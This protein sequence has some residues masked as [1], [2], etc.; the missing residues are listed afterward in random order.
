G[1]PGVLRL[2]PVRAMAATLAAAGR[3]TVRILVPLP[4]PL[5]RVRSQL[6]P[7]GAPRGT[8]A[9]PHSVVKGCGGRGTRPNQ[10]W[11]G[12]T[13]SSAEGSVGTAQSASADDDGPRWTMGLAPTQGARATAWSR[14]PKKEGRARCT[15]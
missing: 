3:E 14:I 9:P 11:F 8:I 6:T 2:G 15:A 10:D 5:R 4:Y 13:A 1:G 12:V 7:T